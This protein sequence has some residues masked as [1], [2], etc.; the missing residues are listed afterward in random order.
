MAARNRYSSQGLL[1]KQIDGYLGWPS[2]GSIIEPGAWELE[3]QDKS[4]GESDEDIFVAGSGCL[5]G[6][7]Y[8]CA[9]R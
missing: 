2:R 3:L 5:H 8:L 1:S 9:C 4:K 6:I 7:V